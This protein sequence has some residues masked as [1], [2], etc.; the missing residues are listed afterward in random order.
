MKEDKRDGND[1]TEAAEALQEE[2]PHPLDRMQK[3]GGDSLPEVDR[4]LLALSLSM[5]LVH[6][7]EKWLEE[8][9]SQ[10]LT[11]QLENKIFI[12]GAEDLNPENPCPICFKP[13]GDE[14]DQHFLRCKYAHEEF[15][16]QEESRRR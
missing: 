9:F 6:D 16:R 10:T 5:P 15:E 14:R 11:A 1:V 13:L 7:L 8:I 4:A 12:G 2:A 3:N